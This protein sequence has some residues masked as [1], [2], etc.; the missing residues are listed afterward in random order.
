MPCLCHRL[1]CAWKVKLFVLLS[2]YVWECHSVDLTSES[3]VGLKLTTELHM[4]LAVNSARVA[5]PVMPQSMTLSCGHW[6]VQRFHA[7]L[8]PQVFSDQM[9][10]KRPDSVTIIPWRGGKVLVWDATCPDTLAPSYIFLTMR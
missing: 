7:S 5:T 10:G 2:D 9:H 1:A 8:N 6:L 3:I 4:A